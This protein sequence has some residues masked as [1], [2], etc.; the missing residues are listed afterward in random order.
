MQG[1]NE[2]L[3]DYSKA[4]TR[5]S[6]GCTKLCMLSLL[7]AFTAPFPSG[8]LVVSF[9][10]KR[11]YGAVWWLRHPLQMSA[12]ISQVV[13]ETMFGTLSVIVHEG[14]VSDMTRAFSQIVMY[15]YLGTY[16]I[17]KDRERERDSKSE[18]PFRTKD[19]RII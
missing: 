6:E 12:N 5:L 8:C 4:I 15:M 1:Y 2:G 14:Y 3:T 10:L 13:F 16:K 11:F 18:K 9:V 19:Y 17:Q 7:G